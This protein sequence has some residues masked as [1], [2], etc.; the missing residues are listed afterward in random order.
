MD[1]GG[2][3]SHRSSTQG[4]ENDGDSVSIRKAGAGSGRD[5]FLDPKGRTFSETRVP[6]AL[7]Y[8]SCAFC[9]LSF[10]CS[11][12]SS[13][14]RIKEMKVKKQNKQTKKE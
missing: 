1:A 7:H 8:L 6:W 13:H 10:C 11:W 4:A 14:F 9:S 3:R 5:L 2:Q 12:N